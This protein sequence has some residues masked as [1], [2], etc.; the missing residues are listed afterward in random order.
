MQIEKDLL[1]D[2]AQKSDIDLVGAVDLKLFAEMGKKLSVFKNIP[3]AFF[4]G[5]LSDRFDASK[6]WSKT[7]GIIS[8]ALSYNS[9]LDLNCFD[10]EHL[11]ISK[12]SYGKDYHVVLKA[13]AENFMQKFCKIYPCEYKIYADTGLLSDRALAYCAGIGFYG[14]NNFIINERFGSF[15]FLGHILIDIKLEAH[16]EPLQRKCGQCE[17]CL[18]ACPQKAY[19]KGKPLNFEKCISYLT[20]RGKPYFETNYIYGC[21]VCQNVC[22]FNA[23]A[24]RDLHEE[25]LPD[26][27]SVCINFDEIESMSEEL[28]YRKYGE[29]ALCWRG[30]K[31]LKKNAQTVKSRS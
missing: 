20:Q 28:F 21:D 18:R 23:K 6:E 29:C 16:T 30:I 1:F 17:K 12:A 31:T 9:S 15:I 24:P 4:S 19:E 27:E 22:P 2:L 5:K 11:C 10:K 3:M 7:K 14:K 13:K 25:F 26:F 8:F